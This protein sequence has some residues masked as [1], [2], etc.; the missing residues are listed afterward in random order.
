MDFISNN[1]YHSIKKI[2]VGLLHIEGINNL[3][4]GNTAD[5]FVAFKHQGKQKF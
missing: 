3:V 4:G 5:V 2:K 1:D